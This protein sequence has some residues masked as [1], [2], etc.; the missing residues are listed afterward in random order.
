MRLTQLVGTAC[1][2]SAPST[3]VNITSMGMA[4]LGA[5]WRLVPRD[6]VRVEA[7]RLP[8]GLEVK[9]FGI[10]VV[11]IEPAASP[12]S[13]AVSPPIMSSRH[14]DQALMPA[15][16]VRWRVAAIGGQCRA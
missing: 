5:P 1:V 13:G 16:R 6:Q 11:V 9:P 15:R 7:L 4:D 2:P 3:V 12:P 14:Q 8:S 10:N